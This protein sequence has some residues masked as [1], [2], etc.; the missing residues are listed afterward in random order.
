MILG[1][2]MVFLPSCVSSAPA[3]SVLMA[4]AGKETIQTEQSAGIITAASDE[5]GRST[6]T[7]W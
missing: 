3:A 4:P 5:Q 7:L 6:C 1:D 2:I